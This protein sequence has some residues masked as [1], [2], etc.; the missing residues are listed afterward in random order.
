MKRIITVLLCTAMLF[1]LAACGEE[2]IVA[3]SYDELITKLSESVNDLFSKNF[4]EELE[5][6]KYTSPTGELED[7]WSAMLKDAKADFHNIDENAFGYK[8]VD[9]NSDSLIEL[10]FMRSDGRLLAVYTVFDGKPLLVEAFNRS[11]QGVVRDTGELYT[12]KLRDDGG[13]DYNV[14]T[15]NP[16][17]GTL[18]NTVSFGTE[19]A[20]CY[21]SI[22]G[23]IYT[24]SDTRIEELRAEYPFEMSEVI[25]EIELSLF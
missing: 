2:K 23:V 10:L 14:H 18:V 24:T 22:E 4:E 7:K 5:E 13:Y 16:S 8:L 11:Y 3:T 19:G 1:A 9:L 17:T 25:G 6:G 12:L 15:L 20:I 21:E